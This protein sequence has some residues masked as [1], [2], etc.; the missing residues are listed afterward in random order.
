MTHLHE[1]FS[2]FF[3]IHKVIFFLDIHLMPNHETHISR[4]LD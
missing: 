3:F 1:Q 2:F 4:P